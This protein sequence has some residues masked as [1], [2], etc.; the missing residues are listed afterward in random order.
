MGTL[1][2]V[3]ELETPSAVPFVGRDQIRG[4][5]FGVACSAAAALVRVVLVDAT[6]DPLLPNDAVSRGTM[7]V[8]PRTRRFL[9]MAAVVHAMRAPT[10]AAYDP[11][12]LVVT[13]EPVPPVHAPVRLPVASSMMSP[14]L[15][16]VNVMPVGSWPRIAVKKV[17]RALVISPGPLLV[18]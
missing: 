12:P 5:V 15:G 4:N 2:P 1:D 7:Y 14:P 11:E 13:V 9:W 16:I 3:I 6:R 10:P 18:P 17:L 8:V